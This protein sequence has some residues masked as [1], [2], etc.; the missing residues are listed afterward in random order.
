MRTLIS[1]SWLLLLFLGLQVTHV[2]AQVSP[3]PLSAGEVLALVAGD[4][5]TDDI[6][7]EISQRGLAFSPDAE[8]CSLV[9]TAGGDDRL[10]GA[11]ARADVKAPADNADKREPAEWLQHIAQAGKLSRGKQYE[12]AAHELVAAIQ[13]DN[14]PEV[15]FV[16]GRLLAGED[17]WQE[18]AQVYSE[19]LLRNPH[20]ADVHAK[21]SYAL[22][23]LGEA[24]D[25]LRE[26]NLAVA[27]SPKSAEAHRNVGIALDELHRPD[28]AEREYREA[29]RIKPDYASAHYDLAIWFY[30]KGELD[31]S[32][33]EYKKSIALDP[34]D[35]RAHYNLGNDY[36]DKG[37]L[38]SAIREFREAKRLNPDFLWARNNLVTAL[39]A[40]NMNAEAAMEL[41]ELVAMNPDSASSHSDLAMA[42]LK[43]NDFSE[44]EKE[45]RKAIELDPS[46]AQS[47][48]GLGAIRLEQKN[49]DAAL[50]EYRKAEQLDESYEPAFWGAATACLAKK[51]FA[52]ALEHLK[53]AES[54]KPSDPGLHEMSG[55]ALAALGKT[56][57]AIAEFKMAISLDPKLVQ[58][59]I[60][61]AA[62][63]EMS[64]DWPG[65][66]EQY[67]QATLTDFSPEI[68][69]KYKAAQG[70]FNQH[71]A[72]LKASGK[73]E[74]AANV[75]KSL[76]AAAVGPNV[77]Q[78]LDAA[79]QAGLNALRAQRFDESVTAY[80]Q[81]V[82][83][84]EKLQPHDDRLPM[85]LFYLGNGYAGKKDF[86]R[87]EK[88]LLRNLEVSK[89][90][91]G[92]GSTSLTLPLQAIGGYYLF[93]EDYDSAID[94]FSRAVTLNQNAFGEVNDEVADT[95][96]LLAS[97]YVKQKAY[98]KAEPILLRAVHIEESLHGQQGVGMNLPIFYL[99]A[100]YE[101]WGKPEKAEPRYREYIAMLEKQY[102]A[103]SPILISVLKDDVRVLQ[104][105]GRSEDAAKVEQRIESIRAAVG[106]TDEQPLSQQAQ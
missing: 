47:H 105:L 79:L 96:R 23:R 94:Y 68:Q 48:S 97:A 53:T 85:A 52:G 34:T 12:A 72:A 58:A 74:E 69:A 10:L 25:A 26:A 63:L 70:R 87:A 60:E 35:E 61:L 81:A 39:E 84:A 86:V 9:S 54:L 2:R 28:A 19:L 101:E 89:E 100:L 4:A 49:Y 90:M 88:T 44:A 6:S 7:S 14:G 93:R 103:D 106:P 56:T 91:Y 57:S 76:H 32:I 38:D 55:Q 42:L 95:L 18:A 50:E 83:L 41:R 16:M 104:K 13:I 51:D 75:E 46:Y 77:S 20:F 67:H 37:D 62:V 15:A 59:R 43:S 71:L 21:L 3:K 8:F 22:H 33:A 78:Q 27:A 29:L 102:G 66:L 65:M 24:E 1:R 45:Y 11:L 5:V 92:A 99:C 80:E 31:Q 30:A 64:G 98:D 82:A 17:R 40:R 36:E 73:S